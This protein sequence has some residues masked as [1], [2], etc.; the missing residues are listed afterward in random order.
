[1]N[2]LDHITL[3]TRA[4]DMLVKPD[5]VYREERE[6]L[7]TELIE[8]ATDLAKEATPAKPPKTFVVRA[9]VSPDDDSDAG[10][11]DIDAE[12]WLKQQDDET[13]AY[14]CHD[15][16]CNDV[17]DDLFWKLDSQPGVDPWGEEVVDR[18]GKY[19]SLVNDSRMDTIGFRVRLDEDDLHI[20]VEKNRPEAWKIFQPES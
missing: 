11:G 6:K 7:A 19:L 9:T 8:A 1:M 16:G 5:P 15:T 12:W 10:T 13:L 18:I 2:T 17:T 3:L 14:L 4:A 20:W